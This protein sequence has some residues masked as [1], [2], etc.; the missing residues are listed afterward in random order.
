MWGTL[1]GIWWISWSWFQVGGRPLGISSN[2]L[3]CL[4]MILWR[5]WGIDGLDVWTSSEHSCAIMPWCPFFNNFFMPLEL[6]PSGIYDNF[7]TT[8]WFLAFPWDLTCIECP[9]QT[10]WYKILKLTPKILK[11]VHDPMQPV[12]LNLDTLARSYVFFYLEHI[13]ETSQ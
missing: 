9:A 1:L 5:S 11:T 13:L 10:N 4:S 7:P 2:T 3:E 8:C 12:P 6:M